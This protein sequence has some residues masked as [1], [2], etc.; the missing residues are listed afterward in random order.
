MGLYDAAKRG[1]LR[2]LVS[3]LL[4]S[5]DP[6]AARRGSFRNSVLPERGRR[7]VHVQTRRGSDRG[8]GS[9]LNDGT[10]DEL[11]DEDGLNDGVQVL[12]STWKGS[13]HPRSPRAVLHDRAVQAVDAISKERR[14]D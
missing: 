4:S 12:D 7:P 6:A 9:P 13:L 11:G 2:L 8:H 5:F 10:D 3:K 14:I 1:R